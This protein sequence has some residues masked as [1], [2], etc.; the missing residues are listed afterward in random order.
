MRVEVG[1]KGYNLNQAN[2]LIMVYANEMASGIVATEPKENWKLFIPMDGDRF[3]ALADKL[4]DEE[5]V[6]VVNMA[7]EPDWEKYPHKIVADCL[8]N[9]A[10]H[11]AE[12]MLEE[13]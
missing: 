4:V 3:Y 5:A 11:A 8:G 7:T 10:V 1:E 6:S 13:V 9:W 12:Q 2:T